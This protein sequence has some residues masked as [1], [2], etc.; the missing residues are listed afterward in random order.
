MTLL[1]SQS[2]TF[3]TLNLTYLK[4]LHLKKMAAGYKI[5]PKV[6]WDLHIKKSIWH[7]SEH[8]SVIYN[9]CLG[10]LEVT[11]YKIVG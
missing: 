11:F 6:E 9:Y 2:E 5:S 8:S 7:K 1:L 10:R 3:N 4:T